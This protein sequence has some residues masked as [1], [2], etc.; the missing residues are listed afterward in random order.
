[1]NT[2]TIEL[3]TQDAEFLLKLLGSKNAELTV[4]IED[5]L[6]ATEE[7]KDNARSKQD[8]VMRIA[9]QLIAV[10]KVETIG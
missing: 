9:K 3:Q 1:M 6:H 8:V 5:N 2:T 7:Q 4:F 10:L